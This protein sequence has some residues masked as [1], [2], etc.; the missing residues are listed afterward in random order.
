MLQ[1]ANFEESSLLN[2]VDILDGSSNIF[3]DEFSLEI[4]ETFEE[5]QRNLFSTQGIKEK[6]YDNFLRFKQLNQTTKL[7]NTLK[8][9]H[10][11]PFQI[12]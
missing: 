10:D 5:T 4:E 6:A 1:S 2:R 3:D 7:N 11:Q 12:K 8:D 9:A